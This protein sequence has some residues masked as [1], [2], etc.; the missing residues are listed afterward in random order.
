MDKMISGLC[1]IKKGGVMIPPPMLELKHMNLA[2]LKYKV[3]MV[4]IK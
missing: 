1:D 2:W 4:Y 3:L